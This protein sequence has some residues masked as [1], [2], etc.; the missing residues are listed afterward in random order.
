VVVAKLYFVAGN[1]GVILVRLPLRAPV[2]GVYL[3]TGQAQGVLV[4][5]TV[6]A[7]AWMEVFGVLGK[8]ER[9]RFLIPDPAEKLGRVV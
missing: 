1:K 3:C 5:G 8:L 9:P 7:P 6:Y 4:A 2:S